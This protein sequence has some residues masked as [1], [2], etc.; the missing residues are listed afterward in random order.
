MLTGL[1]LLLAI[2]YKRTE[3]L[4]M[5]KNLVPNIHTLATQLCFVPAAA[6]M[7]LSGD[8]QRRFTCY[9]TKRV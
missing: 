7:V 9:A 5:I 6:K 8:I 2:S 4:P 1:S 3:W